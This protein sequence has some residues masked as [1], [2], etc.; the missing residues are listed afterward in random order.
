[1]TGR[2]QVT[3]IAVIAVAILHLVVAEPFWL[4]NDDPGMAMAVHGF[5]VVGDGFPPWVVHSNIAWG[6]LARWMPD[7][8]GV[9][10]YTWLS[11]LSL[12]GALCLAAAALVARR[13]RSVVLV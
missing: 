13:F 7:F 12:T 10:G 6:Y 9:L 11:Y 8:G 5:G 4:T 1:M 3:A 2:L